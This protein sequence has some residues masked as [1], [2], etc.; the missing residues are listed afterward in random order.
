MLLPGS[1]SKVAALDAEARH[2]ESTTAV[3]QLLL[4]FTVLMFVLAVTLSIYLTSSISLGRQV[5]SYQ[6]F[7]GE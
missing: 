1:T 6:G 5:L 3:I 4:N 2:V 7:K